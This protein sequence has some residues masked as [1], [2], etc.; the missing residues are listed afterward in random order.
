MHIEGV[1]EEEEYGMN[2]LWNNSCMSSK[3]MFIGPG[4]KD[5]RE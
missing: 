5:S 4:S 3:K 1:F 2:E